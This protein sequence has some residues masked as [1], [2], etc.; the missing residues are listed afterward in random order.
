LLLDVALLLDELPVVVVELLLHAS[1]PMPRPTAV[2]AP[3][4]QA[5]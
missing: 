1:A 2:T 3:K 5:S 4:N